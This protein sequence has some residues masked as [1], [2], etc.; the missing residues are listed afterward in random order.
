MKIYLFAAILLIYLDAKAQTIETVAGNGY[1]CTFYD[2]LPATSFSIYYPTGIAFDMNNNMYISEANRIRKVDPAGIIYTIAGTFGGYSGDGGPATAAML[3]SHAVAVDVQGNIYSADWFNDVIRKINSNGIIST[4]AGSGN[5]AL[6]DGGPATSARLNGPY[7][8]AVDAIG[9]LYIADTDGNRIR[10]VNAATG[11][12]TTI[13]GN[14]SQGYTGDGG[15]AIN[16]TVNSPMGICV[17]HIG[18][19]Y[20]ADWMN[21]CIRKI[22]TTG[23]ITT[24]AGNGVFG[25]GGDGGQAT[26]AQLKRPSGIAVDHLFHLY[27]ADQ[28]NYKIRMVDASGIISTIAGNTYNY[29]G[30]GGLAINAEFKQPWSIALDQYANIYVADH[31]DHR[32]RKISSITGVKE[33]NSGDELLKIFPNPNNGRFLIEFPDFNQSTIRV[34]DMTGKM[35]FDKKNYESKEMD[36]SDLEAGC[37]NLKFVT[38][39]R[40]INK[41]IIIT[42]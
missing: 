9:N 14:G 18:N 20:F 5:S 13:A 26:L 10:K 22:S 24:V 17:D 31:D 16:A 4:C 21:N 3:E 41:K 1:C 38:S 34:F 39:E 2:S 25:F 32:I 8:V 15:L 7:G 37:Y 36:L 27:I 11:I 19:I 29:S 33:V 12:I 35:I 6:G 40:T 28:G 42:K 30:D 23:I